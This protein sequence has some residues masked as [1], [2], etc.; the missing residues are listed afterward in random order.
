[1]KFFYITQILT[2]I[3]QKYDKS[4][5]FLPELGYFRIRRKVLERVTNRNS[6]HP[7]LYWLK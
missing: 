3:L 7:L 6:I 1:M 5:T 2:Q 4:A